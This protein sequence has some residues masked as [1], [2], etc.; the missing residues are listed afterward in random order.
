MPT[1]PL[2]SREVVLP[3]SPKPLKICLTLALLRGWEKQ[4]SVEAYLRSIVQD[5]IDSLRRVCQRFVSYMQGCNLLTVHCWKNMVTVA[6]ATRRSMAFDLKSE[7]AAT[8][9]SLMVDQADP[10]DRCGKCSATERF[11]NIDCALI[12]RNSSSMRSWSSDRLR[13]LARVLR[14]SASRPW[15]RSHLGEKG[16]VDVSGCSQVT[17]KDNATMKIIPTKRMRAGK[18]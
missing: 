3:E 9:C 18:S 7:A 13:R 8:N 17:Q 10:S 14:A 5:G 11:S 2:A 12:S 4:V 15:W 16:Y 6:K 1:T